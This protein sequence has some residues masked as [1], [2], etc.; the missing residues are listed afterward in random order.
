VSP[1]A[2]ARW[3]NWSGRNARDAPVRDAKVVLLVS[4]P[5]A[6]GWARA[7]VGPDRRHPSAGHETKTRG[8]IAASA[9]GAIRPIGQRRKAG[10][11]HVSRVTS[12]S[13]R[14]LA[15]GRDAGDA[16]PIGRAISRDSSD[17]FVNGAGREGGRGGDNLSRYYSRDSR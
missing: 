15:A 7:A 17:M 14:R 10:E 13:R 9:S 11:S 6:K 4:E 12:R 8:K 3:S 2:R 5:C 1:V 16:R